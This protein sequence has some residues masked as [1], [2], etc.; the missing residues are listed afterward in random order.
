MEIN[1]LAISTSKIPSTGML[2]EVADAKV[3]ETLQEEGMI[4]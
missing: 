2:P 4:G 1:A 3:T